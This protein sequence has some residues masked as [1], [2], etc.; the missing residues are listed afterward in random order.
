MTR[1]R[2]VRSVALAVAAC[3]GAVVL[4]PARPGAS[5]AERAEEAWTP[6]PDGIVA[7]LEAR[8]HG[9]ARRALGFTCREAR[10]RV[11]YSGGEASGE[12]ERAYDF[13]LAKDEATGA[14]RG[15]RARPGEPD[16]SPTRDALECPE[17]YLWPLLF[18]EPPRGAL[19][20]R[21]GDW[22]SENGRMVLPVT[23][24]SA[25]PAGDVGSISAWSGTITL[26]TDGN[27]VRLLARP[28]FQDATI[29]ARRAEYIQSFKFNFFGL[30]F[31]TKPRPFGKEVAV[32]FAHA[33]DGFSYPSR[34]ELCTFEQV[35]RALDERAVR[36]RDV[37][38]YSA[39]RFFETY[40][41]ETI[42]P[43]R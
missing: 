4:G 2:V 38:E 10:R 8:A 30:V 32:D 14:L 35:G 40:S 28:N 18:A 36:R 6:L 21:L 11:R 42:P 25:A 41:A 7:T 24:R 16:A 12:R 43:L 23:W 31:H 19:R 15:L 37:A 34:V 26:G 20:F 3:A 5:A 13:L 17:A 1:A 39:Y 33:I 9:F 22:A 27:P 29:A